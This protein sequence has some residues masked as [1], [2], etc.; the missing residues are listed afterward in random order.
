MKKILIL[1]ASIGSGHKTA[2]KAIGYN[3]RMK[4]GNT[5]KIHLL[6]VLTFSEIN[7]IKK[8]LV[9]ISVK[10]MT[11]GKFYDFLW[12]NEDVSK[13]IAN[14][15][16][17]ICLKFYEILKLKKF[18]PS[19]LSVVV[20]THGLA[21]NIISFAKTEYNLDFSHISV[22]TD[23]GLH[24]Y[25]PFSGVDYFIVPT[26][27]M[28]DV[29]VRKGIKESSVLVYGIPLRFEFYSR[30]KKKVVLKKFT[31]SNNMPKALIVCSSGI[32]E[33]S[34]Q[35]SKK[36]IRFLNFELQNHHNF[37]TIIV[38]GVNEDLRKKLLKICRKKKLKNVL[39]LGFVHNMNELMDFSDI[40]ITRP[41]GTTLAESLY[42]CIPVVLVLP[43]YGQ[44]SENATY[45]LD[46]NVAIKCGEEDSLLQS[47]EKVI[48]DKVLLKEMAVNMR[49]LRKEKSTIRIVNLIGKLLLS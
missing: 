40:I 20:T 30:L 6:D 43:A 36:I 27:K 31:V 3:L 12:R 8:M 15:K 13:K 5:V 10:L 39:V 16:K 29:L 14:Y 35:I 25:W 17:I 9:E 7:S 11:T 42:K 37:Y 33:F 22:V 28:R 2:A 1:Y 41:G 18:I 48:F 32:K 44:E 24:A 34:A 45:F 47:I 49:K 4:F 26:D 46:N 19:D 23:F 21:S 38:T